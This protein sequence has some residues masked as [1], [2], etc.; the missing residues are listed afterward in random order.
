MTYG[1]QVP[2]AVRRVGERSEL[3]PETSGGRTED[4]PTVLLSEPPHR[5]RP[6]GA[7]DAGL[8]RGRPGVVLHP[9]SVIAAMRADPVVTSHG[10]RL[11]LESFSAAVGR[12]PGST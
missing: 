7:G 8:C 6:G 10:S 4:G 3:L 5:S 1:H 12:V 2:S 11:R 9:A